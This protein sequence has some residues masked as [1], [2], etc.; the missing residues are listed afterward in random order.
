MN[1]MEIVEIE[2]IVEETPT[3]KSFYFDWSKEVEPGQFV[4]AWVPGKDEF[5]MALSSLGDEKSITVKKIGEGTKALHEMGV[6]DK[7]GVRGPYGKGY[8]IRGDKVLVVIGGYCAS[9]LYPAAQKAK[10]EGIDIV[11]CLGAQT[12][13]ELIFKERLGE[14]SYL[15]ISTDDGSMGHNGY[16]TE[17]ADEYISEVDLVLVCGPEVMMK[18]V[19]DRCIEE[20]TPVQASLERYMKCGIGIC[21]SCTINGY[22]VCRDGPVFSG[23]QLKEMPDFG[24]FERDKTGKKVE[25]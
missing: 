8:T 16:V 11:C 22:Q 9:S 5:P 4:M 14:I 25:F 13:D 2:R 10:D 6:G 23:E 1:T 3:I 19:V 17:I 7:M 24:R 18:K 21:D 20:E 12:A 15:N